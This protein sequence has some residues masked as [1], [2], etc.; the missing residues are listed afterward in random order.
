MPAQRE[1]MVMRNEKDRRLAHAMTRFLKQKCIRGML[2]SI[3]DD[4][5]FSSFRSFW[6]QAPEYVDHP[7]LFGQ[8]HIELAYRGSQT[9]PSGKRPHWI[10]LTLRGQANEGQYQER[11]S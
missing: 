9:E 2:Y 1:Q 4:N 11:Y 6:I 5:L 7:A 3:S 8:F 10:G